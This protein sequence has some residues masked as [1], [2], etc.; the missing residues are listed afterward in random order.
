[1]VT[2]GD[3]DST[4][5]CSNYACPAQ[6]LESL[7][8]FVS[9]DGMDIEG[10]GDKI[11]TA[12]LDAGLINKISDLY[13]LTEE[14][15]LSLDR[16]GPTSARKLIEAIE[17]SKSRPLEKLIFALGI[18]HVGLETASILTT[19]YSDIYALANASEMDLAL[20]PNIGP[21]IA[22][23]IATYFKETDN[24][25]T[26]EQLDR[27][28]VN[29]KTKPA[30]LSETSTL[31]GKVF[32]VTGRL[33]RFTRSQAES[34]IRTLGGIV[35]KNVNKT[36]AYLVSGESPGGKLGQALQ[37]GTKVLSEQ[38]FISIIENTEIEADLL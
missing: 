13:R 19:H 25:S 29:L 11:C 1:M 5:R 15:I 12:I 16:Q 34:M 23:S 10:M 18:L 8:H 36:T 28:K 26:M 33:D 17:Q 31:Q 38:D 35:G 7:K 37:L 6:M 4:P 22:Q 14:D 32:V 24:I 30:P 9:K 2:L 21:K 3:E 27:F 20:L